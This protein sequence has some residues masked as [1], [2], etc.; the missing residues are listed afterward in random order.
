MYTILDYLD[1]SRELIENGR[2]NKSPYVAALQH[3]RCATNRDENTG[4]KIIG[5]K[6]SSWLGTVGYMIVLDIIGSKFRISTHKNKID[7]IENELKPQ[8]SPSLVK[9]LGYFSNLSCEEIFAL[10][11]LRCTFIHDFFL[12]NKKNKKYLHHFQVT[13]GKGKIVT[14]PNIKWDGDLKNRNVNI[15]IVN[16]EALGDLVEEIHSKLLSFDRKNMLKINAGANL[17]YLTYLKE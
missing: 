12:Y 1:P 11:A 10:Y 17:D 7:E 14:L 9:A 15:T 4:E 8:K 2:I 5:V 13:D 3:S 16:L 6:H